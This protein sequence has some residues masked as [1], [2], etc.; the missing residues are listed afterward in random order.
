L[1]A[2]LRRRVKFEYPFLAHTKI[3]AKLSVSDVAKGERGLAYRFSARPK[4]M[5]QKALTPAEKG[6]AM[7]KFMQF[8]SY[9]NAKVN[10]AL[11]ITRMQKEAFLS[12]IEA[13]SL[14]AARLR[15]FFKSKL[16]AR[17]EKSEK[18]MRELKFMA[19]RGGDVFSALIPDLP[20]DAKIALQGVADCVFIEDNAA[21]IVDYKTDI[22]KSKSELVSRYEKQLALYKIILS[23]SLGLSVKECVLYSFHLGAEIM[24][25]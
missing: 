22:V 13:E 23:E 9:E 24:I 16:Y 19:E 18:V 17:I 20:K 6:N 5:T 15:G 7:H 10:L 3:P 11:E 1:L 12:A 25:N 8:S 4:F 2:E 14:D 21:V